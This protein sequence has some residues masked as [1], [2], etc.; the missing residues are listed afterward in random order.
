[1]QHLAVHL[2]FIQHHLLLG[3]SHIFLSAAFTWGGPLMTSILR[4]LR[5]YVEDGSISMTS[6]IV[7]DVD[8]VYS[9]EGFTLERDIFKTL[10]VRLFLSKI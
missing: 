8:F 6:H 9:I 3:A 4:I 10:Q 2:E 1:M 5:T 7:D